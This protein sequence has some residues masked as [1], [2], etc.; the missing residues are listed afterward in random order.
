MANKPLAHNPFAGPYESNPFKVFINGFKA[1]GN[2]LTTLLLMSVSMLA[3]L[4]GG[5]ILL[6]IGGLIA[7][8]VSKTVVSVLMFII[9]VA[10]LLALIVMT[11]VVQAGFLAYAI[12]TVKGNQLEFKAAFAIA[13]RK[14]AG[15]F[16]LMVLVSLIILGGFLLLIIPGF[17][18]MYWYWM[19]PYVYMD[20]DVS[21]SAALKESKRL[22]KGK[23]AEVVGL[24][25][26]S[27]IFQVATAVPFFGYLVSLVLT[28]VSLMAFGYR[29]TSAKQLDVEKKPKPPT[30][31]I[32]YILIFIGP[33]LFLMVLIIIAIAAS[34]R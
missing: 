2:N 5:L 23:F 13:K 22:A 27:M 14:A 7:A 9:G 20:N 19:A 1:L 15:L 25:A 21:I 8:A 12:E 17:I 31:S 16:G 28:P 29:Y 30:D 26:A 24:A 4:G 11:M 33:A 34:G 6:L 3:V 32:N 18:F 10:L